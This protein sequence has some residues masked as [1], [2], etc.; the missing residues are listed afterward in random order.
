MTPP[1]A[2]GQ[3]AAGGQRRKTFDRYKGLLPVEG[4]AGEGW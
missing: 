2:L 4:S 3:A 1:V